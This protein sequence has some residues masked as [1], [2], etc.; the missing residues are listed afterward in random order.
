MAKTIEHDERDHANE[1]K[2]Q[3]LKYYVEHPM[4]QVATLETQITFKCN[5]IAINLVDPT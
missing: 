5:G 4:N 2:Q 3:G 1:L